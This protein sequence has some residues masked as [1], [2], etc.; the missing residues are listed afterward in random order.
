MPFEYRTAV[1]TSNTQG[2]LMRDVQNYLNGAGAE[3]FYFETIDYSENEG[4]GLVRHTF[5][6]RVIVGKAFAAKR[7]RTDANTNV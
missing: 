1:I 2:D 7:G 5:T 6:A 3:D 4:G